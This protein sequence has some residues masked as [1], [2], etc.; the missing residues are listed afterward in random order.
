MITIDQK[1]VEYLNK[2]V[3][4]DGW[5]IGN[6][7]LCFIALILCVVLVGLVGIEREKRGRSAEILFLIRGY[8]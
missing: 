6:M 8:G 1:I 5:P 3:V 7:I 2:W 4:G